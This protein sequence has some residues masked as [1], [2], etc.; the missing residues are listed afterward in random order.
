[1]KN[2]FKLISLM[3]LPIILFLME[4]IL[5]HSRGEYFL[6]DNYDGPYGFL[7]ASLN[8]AQFL[9]PGYFQHPGI[10]PLLIEASTIKFSY[11]LQGV[12]PDIVTDTFNRP[13]FYFNRINIVFAFLTSLSLFFL[14]K[15]S[16]DKMGSI[17]GSIFLQFTPFVSILIL[18]QLTHNYVSTTTV[19]LVIVLLTLSISYLNE[20]SFSRK[21]NYIYIIIFGFVC[22]LLLANLI[23]LLPIFIIPFLLIK[24]FRNKFIFIS[25]ALVTFFILFFSIS[26]DSSTIWKFVLSNIIHSGKYGAGPSEFI[27]VDRII[28]TLLNIYYEFV[29]FLF[30]YLLILITLILQFIPKLKLKIRSNKYFSLLL[31]IFIVMSMYILLVI[32]Q[33]E[34]YYL[35]PGLLFTIA[36]L[37]ILNSIILDLFPKHPKLSK[38]LFLYIFLIIFTFPQIKSY[39]NYISFYVKRKIESYKIVKYIKDNYPQTIIVSSDQTASMPTAFYNA[40]NYTGEQKNKYLSIYLSQYLSIYLYLNSQKEV[41]VYSY[42]FS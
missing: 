7:L 15:I 17:L 34:G 31:G 4:I 42:N 8:M 26:P 32:K 35:L 33:K 21:K 30:V 1:M 9:K 37:F 23:S 16:Y 41:F 18:Y 14:G 20:K 29:F 39:N 24:T 36:G 28:P 22:G 2:K 19:I 11:F 6:Y 10:I 25:V 27:D 3:A 40:L 12:D 5:K 38:Y 13:E